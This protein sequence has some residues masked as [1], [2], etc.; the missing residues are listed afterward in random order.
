M[1]MVRAKVGREKEG[2]TPARLLVAP[3]PRAKA[4][5]NSRQDGRQTCSQ[6]ENAK[7]RHYPLHPASSRERTGNHFPSTD[8]KLSSSD[9]LKKQVYSIMSK[10]AAS[11]ADPD[12]RLI[13]LTDEPSYIQEF[14]AGYKKKATQAFASPKKRR[15][16]RTGTRSSSSASKKKK[17]K[18]PDDVDAIDVDGDQKPASSG[19]ESTKDSQVDYRQILGPLRMSFIDSFTTRHAFEKTSTGPHVSSTRSKTNL[20]QLYKELVEYQL[21]LPVEKHSAIYC[22]ALESDLS[23]L[24]VM[25]TGPL[26]T[27]YA[28]GCFLF[29]IEL[30][31]YPSAAPQVK[32]ITTGGG[33]VRFNPNLYNCGKICLSLLGTWQG[34]GWQPKKSTLLQV[35]V[36]IQGLIMVPDPYFNEPGYERDRGKPQ[37][38]QR[39]DDY[40]RNLY[41]HTLRYAVL[42]MMEHGQQRFPEFFPVIQRHFAYHQDFLLEK[43]QEWA[44]ESPGTVNPLIPQVQAALA[45]LPSLVEQ[46]RRRHKEPET[47]SLLEAEPAKQPPDRKEPETISLLE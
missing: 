33:R 9:P 32:L 38:K 29:D 16:G 40:N 47:I 44:K 20:Q 18:I 43:M 15:G 1:S 37:G 7:K 10:A 25:L 41:A 6:R 36:S 14:A 17:E 31:N 39:S 19:D 11:A 12:D 26:D 46:P 21:N 30:P 45:S 2:A 22:R 34:P 4:K 24:R 3:N 28:A 5:V 23:R 27:P 8:T 35:L 42:E 13:D